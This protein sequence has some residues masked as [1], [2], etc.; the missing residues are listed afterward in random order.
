MI[1]CNTEKNSEEKRAEG[2]SKV[3]RHPWTVGLGGKKESM[4]MVPIKTFSS[5]FSFFFFFGPCGCFS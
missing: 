2:S 4:N 3:A 5:N 1:F